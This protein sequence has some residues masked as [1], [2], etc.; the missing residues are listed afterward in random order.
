MKKF[1]VILLGSDDNVY[2]FARTLKDEYDIIPYAL[3]SRVLNVTCNTKIINFVVDKNVHDENKFSDILNKLIITLKK[4]YEKIIVIP[5]SDYYMEL[6]VKYAD[7][8]KYVENKF[9]DYK[10]YIEFNNKEKFYKLCDKYGISYPKSFIFYKQNYKL[11]IDKIDI[12][13]PVILKPNNSNSEEYLNA[14]FNNKKKVYYIENKNE[15]IKAIKNIYSSEYK[16]LLIVQQYIPGDDTNMRVLNVY[17]DKNAEVK[18]MSLGQPIL[19]EYHPNTYGNYASIIS[20]TEHIDIMDK[21]KKFLEDIKYYGTANFDIKYNKNDGKY[22]AFEINPRP[23]RSSF[24]TACA[25]KSLASCYVEDLVYNDLKYHLNNDKQILWLNVPMILLKKYVKNKEIR[26]KIKKL[27]KYHTLLYKKD[28]S[29][30]RRYVVY[31]NYIS[32]IKYFPKYYIEKK[33]N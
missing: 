14:K 13:Y 5:C 16:D 17:C 8:L 1:N 24:F 6:C 22:Y 25:G 19:E 31:R 30:K 20:L 12:D 3:T 11:E 32:K 23:G 29:I 9:I 18:L 27:K 7:K 10:K 15:L 28:L 21:I 33:D 2:G 26:K 4:D